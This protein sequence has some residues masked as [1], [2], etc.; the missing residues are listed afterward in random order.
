MM[1]RSKFNFQQFFIDVLDLVKFKIL[2]FSL[3]TV[4]IGAFLAESVYDNVFYF[5]LFYLLIGTTF[6]FSAAASFN[7]AIE[8]NTDQMMPRTQNRP[9]VSKRLNFTG[10]IFFS[11]FFA[12]TGSLFL[13]YKVNSIVFFLSLFIL[14]SYDFFYTPLKKI[15]WVNTIVGAI[16]GGMPV[17]CG[18]FAFSDDVTLQI[19][20]LFLIFFLW[21]LPHFFSIAWI[22][23]DA[24]KNASIK[25]ISENDETG[26][27]TSFV[28]LLSTIIL[29]VVS[30]IPF[31]F[32]FFSFI[33]FL[34]M[35][36]L[37]II[38]LYYC[39][40]FF[41]NPT[42]YSARLVLRCSLLYPPVI[43]I[44]ILF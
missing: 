25:M 28:T 37:G 5:K 12:I 10:V 7:H 43:L 42:V 26:K 4:L 1:E 8:V 35:I 32:N 33:Y 17:L 9:L 39:V 40:L 22:Q 14:V 19:I 6:V 3:L 44:L 21:Q 20:L 34:G 30:L 36:I 16:P 38:F 24:Y 23:K 13:Y 41:L 2:F 15:S 31:Y 18:W 27:L 29:F 11:L